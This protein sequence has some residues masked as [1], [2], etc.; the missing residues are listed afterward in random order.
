MV[1]LLMPIDSITFGPNSILALTS[2]PVYV[3]CIPKQYQSNGRLL[4][5][6]RELFPAKSVVESNVGL[7]ITRLSKRVLERNTVLGNLEHAIN[8]KRVKG[9]DPTHST[10]M[11]GAKVSSIPTYTAELQALNKKVKASIERLELLDDGIHPTKDDAELGNEQ[12]QPR[13]A[14]ELLLEK[15]KATKAIKAG[16]ADGAHRNA[17]FVSF[18]SL[19]SRTAALQMEQ[20]DAPFEMEVFEA[21]DPE[22]RPDLS[23]ETVSFRHGTDVHF[24]A[25]TFLVG[26]V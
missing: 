20:Y 7:Q 5:H 13:E 1:E 12:E 6:F 23:N 16:R 19:R 8:V 9:T 18:N 10:S 25:L 22:G 24:L 17:A 11:C 3:Q 21:P 15:E 26:F 14:D 2:I 4:N